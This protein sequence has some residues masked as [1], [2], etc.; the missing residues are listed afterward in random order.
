MSERV[1]DT[2][3]LCINH[4]A[5]E[6]VDH[7]V[8]REQSGRPTDCG[9]CTT[10]RT[11][12]YVAPHPYLGVLN[13]RVVCTDCLSKAIDDVRECQ[14][15]WRIDQSVAYHMWPQLEALRNGALR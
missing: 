11:R 9:Y 1:T 15:V 3:V 2:R 12:W 5:C 4:T 8:V 10:N 7:I 6:C 13:A 14:R